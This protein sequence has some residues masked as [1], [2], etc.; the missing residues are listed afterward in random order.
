MVQSLEI[1]LTVSEKL[2]T[3]LPF[4]PA[5]CISGHL[6][7][8]NE[9]A[10]SHRNLYT[11]KFT[12]IL[13]IKAQYRNLPRCPSI[14]EWCNCGIL[15]YSLTVGYPPWNNILQ[16]KGTNY[17]RRKQLGWISREVWWV[18]NAN[19]KRLHTEC[20]HLYANPEVRISRL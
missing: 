13:F 20:F 5:N 2:N 1:S 19:L 6:F 14:G 12:A 15:W 11:K 8:W 4:N 17:W 10:Q 16:H 9:D 7:Q 3:Q 18:K